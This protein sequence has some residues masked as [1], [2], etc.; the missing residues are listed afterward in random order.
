M[1][2]E[3]EE[4]S[5]HKAAQPAHSQNKSHE[6][7]RESTG[8]AM[9]GCARVVQQLLSGRVPRVYVRT[10]ALIILTTTVMLALVSIQNEEQPGCELTNSCYKVIPKINVADA[11]LHGEEGG[12]YDDD[13]FGPPSI[14]S[15]RAFKVGSQGTKI[16]VKPGDLKDS[17]QARQ[18][19]YAQNCTV[20][21]T[22]VVDY[23]L[24]NWMENGI[25]MEDI[26]K[27]CIRKAI[28][29]SIHKHEVR[30]MAWN[31][32]SWYAHRVASAFWMIQMAVDRAIARGNPIPD[33]EIMLQPGDGT[34]RTSPGFM[35]WRDAAP[36]LSNAKCGSDDPSVSFPTTLHDQFGLGTGQM[37]IDIW[38]R[39]QE[40]LLQ[41]D[42]PWGDKNP[43]LFFSAKDGATSRGNR[44][45]LFAINSPHVNIVGRPRPLSDYGEYQY[46]VYAYGHCGWSRR[47]HELAHLQSVVLME[48]SPCREYMHHVFEE[49]VDYVAVREDFGDVQETIEQLVTEPDKSK[50]MAARWARKGRAAMSLACSLQYVEDLLRRYASLQTF[51]PP[52]RNTWPLYKLNAPDSYFKKHGSDGDPDRCTFEPPRDGS[53]PAPIPC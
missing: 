24:G 29:I 50:D 46:L 14:G 33:L 31:L 22:E 9:Q 34:F 43:T 7:S 5:L 51:V 42:I 6:E 18:K 45:N 38:Q 20:D 53:M 48:G 23:Q 16:T 3:A 28:R 26:D 40:I 49:G 30:H 8:S 37:S 10:A 17:E 4:E 13:E 19:V 36:L 2:Q 27:L 52:R 47:L 12:D 44:A 25:S 15:K 1:L 11:R 21:W 35:Q 41:S 39:R 32:P